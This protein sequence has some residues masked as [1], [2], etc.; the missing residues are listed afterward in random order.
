M[1]L[2]SIENHPRGDAFPREQGAQPLWQL[3]GRLDAG[4]PGTDHDDGRRR[5]CRRIVGKLSQVLLQGKGAVIGVDVE[6]EL[7]QPRYGGFEHVTARRQHQSVVAVCHTA[8]RGDG[9]GAG[10][11]GGHLGGDVRNAD[12]VEQV[13]ERDAAGAQIGFVVANPDVV[14]GFGAQHGDVDRARRHGELVESPGGAECR[15]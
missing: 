10:V 14:E 12:R 11:D 6:T 1:G 7:P 15:P 3:A 9:A 4:Q 5:R 2:R 8:R 13:G